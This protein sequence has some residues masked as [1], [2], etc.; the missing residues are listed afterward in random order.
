MKDDNGKGRKEK[1]KQEGKEKA[2]ITAGKGGNGR[3]K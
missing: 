1:M 3:K 2:T